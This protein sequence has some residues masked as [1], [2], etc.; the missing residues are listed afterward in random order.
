LPCDIAPAPN[1]GTLR[2]GVPRRLIP[3]VLVALALASA[4]AAAAYA[5]AVT[6]TQNPDLLVKVSITPTHP[7]VGQTMVFHVKIMNLTGRTLQ[8][9]WEVAYTTPDSGISA[10]LDGPQ[11]PGVWAHESFRRKVTAATAKG[12]YMLSAEAF[13]HHGSSH[14]SI[15]ATVG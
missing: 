10:A 15:H 3:A 9:G 11:G 12:R 5:T 4:G 2:A 8:G 6:G 1:P 7:K 13:D 14:A